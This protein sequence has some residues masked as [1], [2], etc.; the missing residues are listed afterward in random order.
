MFAV[1][2]FVDKFFEL[3]Q[4]QE[5]AKTELLQTAF[6]GKVLACGAGALVG[7]VAV[8]NLVSLLATPI[9]AT[10]GLACC[11]VLGLI[12][13][14]IFIVSVNLENEAN[15]NGWARL[16]R[17]V[18]RAAQST[19]DPQ[20]ATERFI[21]DLVKGTCVIGPTLHAVMDQLNAAGRS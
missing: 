19:W 3:S 16:T 12:C 1:N 15:T 18:S 21:K 13:R 11:A 10:L 4:D 5:E 7:A 20:G 2:A 8:A 6:Q 14:D 9:L 17:D